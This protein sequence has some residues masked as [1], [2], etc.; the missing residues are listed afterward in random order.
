MVDDTDGV[1]ETFDDSLRVALTVASHFGERLAR[2]REQLARQREAGSTH[3]GR[4]LTARM[5][6]ERAAA[7][8]SLAPIG[9]AE[10]WEHATPTDIARMQETAVTWRDTDPEI[11]AAGEKIRDEVQRRYGIDSDAPG[12]TGTAVAAAVADAERDRADAAAARVRAGEDLT[13]SQLLFAQADRQDRDTHDHATEAFF[14]DIATADVRS[15]VTPTTEALVEDLMSSNSLEEGSPVRE[16]AEGRYDSAARRQAFAAELES[17]GID[18]TT[19][20]ARILADGENAKHPSEAVNT[21]PGRS[22]R[23]R[24]TGT[25]NSLQ[26]D[27]G[28]RSR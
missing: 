12:I 5:D 6:A 25:D 28:T 15:E 1:G 17:R 8:A 2:L 26:R 9:Q 22:V 7:R 16:A 27:R 3:E 23:P 4:E 11:T 19:A 13:L 21:R 10:W 18:Q 24:V 14:N 20:A